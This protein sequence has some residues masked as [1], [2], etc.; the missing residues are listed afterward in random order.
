M[1]VDHLETV[2]HHIRQIARKDAIAHLSD[3]D[4]LRRF[5]R[6]R[7]DSAFVVLVR[8]HGPL[9]LGACRRILHHDQDAEDAFQ[10]T[11]LVLVRKAATL[12]SPATLANWLYGVANRTALGMRRA[13]VKRR[14]KEA[15]AMPRTDHEG[16]V[17]VDFRLAFDEELTKVPDKYREAVILCDLQAKTRREAA[18]ELGCAEGTVASR[19][20]RGR[21]LLAQRLARRG[22]GIGIGISAAAVASAGLGESALAQV[23]P[24]L[25]ASTTKAAALL[26]AGHAISAIVSSSIANATEGSL[27]SMFLIKLKSLA[28]FTLVLSAGLSV[29]GLLYQVAA[30]SHRTSDPVPIAL[31]DGD[32]GATAIVTGRVVDERGA[33]VAGVSIETKESFFRP[34]LRVKSDKDGI[35]RIA[36]RDWPNSAPLVADDGNG[37]MGILIES[38]ETRKNGFTIRLLPSKAVRIRVTNGQDQPIADSK[39]FL[40]L[41]SHPTSLNA[42]TASD[43]TVSLHYPREAEVGFVMAWKSGAGFDYAST[44]VTRRERE[45]RPLPDQIALHL[46][47]S[48]TVIVKAVDSSERPI[49]G[50]SIYPWTIGKPGK[51]EEVNLSGCFAAHVKTDAKGIAV[52]DWLPKDFVQGISFLSLSHD[53]SRVEIPFIR[54][55]Q[56]IEQLPLHFLRMGKL[57][58]KVTFPDGR[59]V[60]NINISGSGAGPAFHN[61]KGTTRTKADGTY[62]MHV[63]SEEAYVIRVVDERWAAP[64]RIGVL[65]RED[66]PI[67]NVDFTLHE[68]TIL[69]GTVTVGPTNRPSTEEFIVLHESGGEIPPEIRKPGDRVYHEI[70]YQ[71]GQMTNS[72]G[73]Y[74]FCV[75]PGTYKLFLRSESG[76]VKTIVVT[77]KREIVQDFHRVR[78]EWGMLKGR[79]VDQHGR[80]VGGAKI[81]GVYRRAVGW[82]DPE[83]VSDNDGRF[84]VRRVQVPTALFANTPDNKL[85]GIV[86]VEAD[87]EEVTIRVAP[88]ARAVG[89]LLNADGVVVAGSKIACGIR[90]YMGEPPNAP[91]STRFGGS[92][93]T[94]ADGRFVIE[95]L[96]PGEEY[97]FNLG[98]DERTG[99]WLHLTMARAARPDTIQL[100]ELR[101]PK[102]VR[103]TTA[104]EKAADY[105]R[106]RGH[107]VERLAKAQ[108]EAQ[109]RRSRIVV[110]VGDA[111]ESRTQRFCELIQD[112]KASS[113]LS[114]VLGRF[115]QLPVAANDRESMDLLRQKYGLG[116]QPIIV[117][118]L[119]VI[120]AKGGVLAARDSWLDE[121]NAELSSAALE[122]FLRMH[123]IP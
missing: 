92:A 120:D 61:F 4:L 43:G 84:K 81:A 24:G 9:V 22:I 93:K 101:S 46:T 35:V 83:S 63:N 21:A 48:R 1:P 16:Q 87:Q 108:A 95:G 19:L 65:V 90:I 52:F 109:R 2:V 37:R 11:F 118:A 7:D 99:H 98:S 79:V 8:R 114:K 13:A 69:R 58:G 30:A 77:D 76:E 119:A 123:S 100:G 44:L 107:L 75:G 102:I 29:A 38:L 60:A 40:V 55:D 27:K 112:E 105:F 97:E 56:P 17:P 96:M 18:R 49:E 15:L 14:A 59:P 78:S 26:A 34:P 25:T 122:E 111:R 62:E 33:P 42:F 88:T 36:L 39:V 80:P 3:P 110:I 20:A 68:G 117:P 91:F 50:V 116:S 64:S 28:T 12:R 113:A 10:A 23:P 115:I 41:T 47:G 73:E 67:E 94:A 54:P 89:R 53:H 32:Q 85:A 51:V 57:S 5:L 82:V 103:E 104:G 70:H 74:R 86:H 45:R 66:Q 6:E 72:R 106:E 121:R 71:T 31:A